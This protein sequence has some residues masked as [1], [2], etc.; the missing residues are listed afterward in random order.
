MVIREYV[1]IAHTKVGRIPVGRVTGP[2]RGMAAHEAKNEY[3]GLELELVP[4]AE[5]RAADLAVADVWS[6]H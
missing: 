4:T 1:V 5:A 2:L 3:P 6:I